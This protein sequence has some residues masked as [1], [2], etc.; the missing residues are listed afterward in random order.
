MAALLREEPDIIPFTMLLQSS[1]IAGLAFYKPWRYLLDKGLGVH[2]ASAAK[3]YKVVCPHASM[4]IIHHYNTTTSWS[5]V[6]LLNIID[7]P[8]D[9]DADINTPMGNLSMTTH[10]KTLD[11]TM[12]PWVLE[13]GHLIETLDDYE[14]VKFLIED[15]EYIPNYKNSKEPEMIIGDSGIVSAYVPKSPFQSMNMI[16]GTHN[17]AL[18]LYMHQKEFDELYRIIYKKELEICKIVAESPIEVIWCAD[19]V[20]S[21]VT[22]PKLFEKYNL[23]FYNEAADIFHKNDKIYV[24][25]MDGKLKNLLHLIAKTRIDAIES[26][27][28]PPIGD[29]PLK[30]AK[31]A[32][33]D[34]VIWANFPES[35]SLQG[36]VAVREKTHEML[37]N[38]A[39]GNNFLMEI[40]EDFPSFLHLLTSVPTILKTVL[41]YGK[42]PIPMK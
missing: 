21:L 35:I 12:V 40:S 25:H 38:A 6:D 26:F 30:E 18:H 22:S 15:T 39:P 28:P 42:Y 20:T 10:W 9:V 2:A 7:T 32:W 23:P 3:T 14:V 41:K 29:L 19:N 5:P 4:D 37:K 33:K 13:G 8:H 1:H 16:M 36:Q 17:L 34:K 27:T 11:L 31:E 24:V